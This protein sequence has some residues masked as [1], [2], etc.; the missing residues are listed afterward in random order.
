MKFKFIFLII[1]NFL[2]NEISFSETIKNVNLFHEISTFN[3]DGTINAV[4]EISSG[5]NQKWQVSKKTGKLEWEKKNN[6]FRNIK[7]LGY[8]VNYGII[9]QTITPKDDGGDGDPIDI[10][11]IGEK[12]EKGSV[13]KVKIIGVMKM[14]DNGE[15][16]D[17]LLG[18]FVDSKVI[19]SNLLDDISDLEINYPGMLE[20]FKIWFENYKGPGQVI[21][22]NFENKIEALEIIKKSKEPYEVLKGYWKNNN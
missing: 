21:V 10:L 11:V 19:N 8:P 20:I 16:D 9:P 3:E 12:F 6:S 15:V 1:L 4:I 14:L 13:V 18:I 7:Y 5:E 22:Q 17:K 2:I